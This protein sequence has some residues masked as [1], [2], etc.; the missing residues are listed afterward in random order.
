VC[1]LHCVVLL[2]YTQHAALVVL[3]CLA[4]QAWFLAQ[5]QQQQPWQHRQHQPPAL[6]ACRRQQADQRK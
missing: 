1:R 6:R 5:Q 3:Q 2:S 4:Q